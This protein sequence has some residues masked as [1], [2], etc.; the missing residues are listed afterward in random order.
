[1]CYLCRV[2]FIDRLQKTSH[3]PRLMLVAG[4]KGSRH[5][6]EDNQYALMSAL[7]FKISN[8]FG[9]R[10]GIDKAGGHIEFA[11]DHSERDVRYSVFLSP[12]CYATF[13]QFL[14]FRREEYYKTLFY[15]PAVPIHPGRNVATNIA[16]KHA[17]CGTGLRDEQR[18][19]AST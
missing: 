2:Y 9:H 3:I 17:L 1:M 6:I 15:L 7:C 14:T 12:C 18:E 8:G 5:G 13:G 4:S 19:F 11:T 16:D 10:L